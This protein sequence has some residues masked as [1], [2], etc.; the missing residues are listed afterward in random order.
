[1]RWDSSYA[2]YFVPDQYTLTGEFDSRDVGALLYGNNGADQLVGGAANDLLIGGSGGDYLDGR[3]GEDVYVVR[4]GEA[5]FDVIA[6]S[7]KFIKVLTETGQS[8]YADWYYQS[9]GM[10]DYADRRSRGE[11]IPELPALSPNDFN[12]ME[13][14]FQAGVIETDVV[15]FSENIELNQLTLTWGELVLDSPVSLYAWG[16]SP[17]MDDLGTAFRTLDISWASGE[18]V[19]IVIP[20]TY[21]VPAP[22]ED[23]ED[24]PDGPLE[25]TL[26]FGRS[27]EYLG[28]GIELFRF[29]DG[30]TLSMAEMIALAPPAPSFDPQNS[31]GNLT[32]IG[33][34]GNDTLIGQNGDDVLDGGAGADVMM[35]GNGNDTYYVDDI[36][37][38]VTESLNE[39]DDIINSSV[40]Y[41]LTSNVEHLTLTGADAI[42]GTGNTLS[43]ILTGNAAANVLSGD[44]GNDTLRGMAGNDLLYSGAGNDRLEV[45][46][47]TD[48]AYGG[49][50]NDT[51]IGGDFASGTWT[52]ELLYGEDGDD[53]LQGGGKF[54]SHLYGGAGNDQLTGGT[55]MSILYGEEGDDILIAGTGYSQ[56]NGGAGADRMVGNYLGNGYWIDNVNDVIVEVADGGVDWVTSSISY[57]L[58]AELENITLEGSDAISGTG[59]AGNNS[60]NGT[61]NMAANVLSGGQGDDIYTLGVGDSVVENANEGIDTV[62]AM[63]S[64]TLGANVEKLT[65]MGNGHH[66]ATGNS[67]DNRLQGNN[68]NNSLSGDAGNDYLNGM[69]GNDVLNGGTG[70][71][72][73]LGGYGN[74][75]YHVDDAGDLVT[76]FSGQG[77]DTVYSSISYAL[78]S[79]VE[80]LTLT[81]TAAIDGTGNSLSNIMKGNA[82]A[83]VL[84]GDA[85]NDTLR[86]MAG[87]DTLYGGA[88]NDGLTGGQGNDTYRFSRGGGADTINDYDALDANPAV[89]GETTDV[90]DITGDVAHDQLWFTRSGNDLLMH[91]IGTA[92]RM[93]IQGWY[94]GSEYQVEEIHAGDGYQLMNDQVDQLV[95]AM[96]AFAP[97]ASGELNLSGSYR[98][99]LDPVIAANWQ[100]A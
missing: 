23:D 50:G 62:N 68:H 52:W 27:D 92:D 67:L 4:R 30:T 94:N 59:N 53:V 90:I 42:D 88:G 40:S 39:G 93:T 20:H 5:G 44:A 87:D 13:Q 26:D 71:D 64:Y 2:N 11:S 24:G 76:E 10:P 58:S 49:S 89:Y 48:K 78:T 25:G 3:K 100:S 31:D 8:R 60:L 82:A 69:Y 83:N 97:P 36:G 1:M 72:E 65:L 18:G 14:L 80:H 55:G 21:V 63:F 33:T 95:Q 22:D 51:L 9:I 37:D 7:G 70:A 85:G 98:T 56:L 29:A 38:V 74:D 28:L 15:E 41:T 77:T 46:T 75:T 43:N 96:A 57:T 12:A 66:H 79:N 73:M 91:V 6:D 47:G 45:G 16:E 54:I 19:R 84:S 17:W 81:G 99:D 35:G 61:G 86:G 34:P 32:L